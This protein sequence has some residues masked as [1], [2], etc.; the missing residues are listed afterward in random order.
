MR[1]LIFIC[2]LIPGAAALYAQSPVV[3]V[4]VLV[5]QGMELQDFA[6]PAD[7]FNKANTITRGAYQVYTVSCTKE[8]V[9]TDGHIGIQPDY[10]MQ[11]LPKPDILVI[12]GA[13][14]SLPDS[15]SR[16]STLLSLIRHYQDS[17]SVIMSVSSG[18][19]LLASAGLLDQQAATTH[20][21]LADDFVAAFPAITLVKDVRYVD[22]GNIITT[23]GATAGIDAA[24]HLVERYSGERIAGMVAR[25]MQ[26]SP[27]REE[28][29]PQ[30]PTGMD[31][32]KD[33]DVVCGMIAIDK[34]TYASYQGKR[35]YFCSEICKK[36]FLRNPGQYTVKQ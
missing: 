10:N 36:T 1:I 8:V 34:N 22:I 21:F 9:Y 25:A 3:K 14:V 33:A 26:Y 24:L 4:A 6:G 5:Y 12:P 35:Y 27:R 32:K 31:Y 7:V 11:Q 30:A 18:A 13:A 2:L 17:V 19:F 28:T 15:L 23:A 16:D 29:W 20:F